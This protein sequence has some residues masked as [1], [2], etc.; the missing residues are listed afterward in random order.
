MNHKKFIVLTGLYAISIFIVSSIPGNNLPDLDINII[1]K[2]FH[3]LAYGILAV[4]SVICIKNKSYK[5]L[6]LVICLG[7]LYG[8]LI[9][10]WQGMVVCREASLYDAI[11]NGIGMIFGSFVTL[12]YLRFSH[13]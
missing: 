12:K 8:G 6:I 13:D 11:A 3:I 2:I 7:S 9:E 4:L 1:D 5:N 10:I